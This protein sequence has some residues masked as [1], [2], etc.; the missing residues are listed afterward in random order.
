[1]GGMRRSGFVSRLKAM[2]A[3]PIKQIELLMG[4]TSLTGAAYLLT[5]LYAIGRADH[6]TPLITTLTHVLWIWA[7]VLAVGAVILLVGLYLKN[8]AMRS[9]GLSL[10]FLTRLYQVITIFIVAGT[11]PL[12]WLY[13]LTLCLFC[14]VLRASVRRGR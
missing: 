13:P 14:I 7:I 1:M 4:I 11:F 3:T 12:Q 6:L 9:L 10:I 8:R 5:P 2:V